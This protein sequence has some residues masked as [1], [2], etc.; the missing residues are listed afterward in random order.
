[1]RTTHDDRPP[2]DISPLLEEARLKERAAIVAWLR[3]L[4]KETEPTHYAAPFTLAAYI[5]EE[6]H[7]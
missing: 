2:I 5:E 7:L 4:N 1:M 6:A 3:G